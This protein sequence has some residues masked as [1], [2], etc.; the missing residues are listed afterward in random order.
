MTLLLFLFLLAAVLAACLSQSKLNRLRRSV[1]GVY[2]AGRWS[3]PNMTTSEQAEIWEKLRD[4]ARL[5]PGNA[6]R[7]GA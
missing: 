2:Y 6:R 3:C 7:R 4:E 1:T 5:T